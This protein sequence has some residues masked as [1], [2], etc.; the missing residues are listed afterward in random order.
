MAFK[1]RFWITL[2]SLIIL[3]AIVIIMGIYRFN[4]TNADI[5]IELA[6]GEVVQY[7]KLMREAEKKG[8]S[9]VMLS[10]FSI[11][12]LEDFIV[13]LPE[14]DSTPIAVPLNEI[15]KQ[16]MQR[17]ATGQYSFGEERGSI[18]LDFDTI[19]T[20]NADIKDNQIIFAAPFSVSNQGSGVFFYLGLFS[21]DTKRHTIKHID[22]IFI[23]DRINIVSIEPDN[24]G[25]LIAIEYTERD[26][27]S[28]ADK[29]TLSPVTVEFSLNTEQVRFSPKPK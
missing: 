22:S 11:R 12:T 23:G 20:I 6:D 19:R 2:S 25:R 16:E 21:Q 1:K 15:K 3:P 28:E 26:T 4:Y 9:K 13:F 18:S 24:Q 14:Q 7:D 27:A 10:L 8:Y 5:Y 29:T 17:W